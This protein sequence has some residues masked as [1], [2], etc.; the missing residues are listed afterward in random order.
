MELLGFVC[1]LVLAVL[2]GWFDNIHVSQTGF[3]VA[4]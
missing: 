3:K 4:M 2:V 1:L